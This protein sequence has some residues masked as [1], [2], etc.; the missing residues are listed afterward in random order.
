MTL[1]LVML[2][3]QPISHAHVRNETTLFKRLGIIMFFDLIFPPT[4]G[5]ILGVNSI[6]A[7]ANWN[8]KYFCNFF[9]NKNQYD[10]WLCTNW[11]EIYPLYIF[12][13]LIGDCD[14][15]EWQDSAPCTKSCGFGSK[16]GTK[17]QTRIKKEEQKHGGR[18]SNVTTRTIP[19]TSHVHCPSKLYLK[20][21]HRLI[22]VFFK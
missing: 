6:I 2:H 22:F 3:V 15:H 14:W 19:C 21:L 7:Y 9:S 5:N 1:I 10:L 17:T 4:Q 12:Y 18:C 8:S 16:S 13:C 11:R 20:I